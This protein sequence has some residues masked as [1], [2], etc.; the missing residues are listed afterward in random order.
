MNGIVAWFARNAVAANLLM[1]VAFVGGVFG[2]TKMEQEMFPVVNI[3]G[4]SVSVA[5]NGA[6]PQDVE[7]Q[8]VTRIE[9]AVADINGLDRITSIANEGFGVVNIKGRDD[10]DMEEFLDEVKIRVDQINN[11]PQAAFEPQVQRWEQ[12]NWFMGM[13][14][15]GNVDDRTLKRLADQVRDD[16]ANISGGELAVLQGVIDEQVNIEVSEEAL[17]RFGL[18]F[19]DVA[20]AIRRSSLNSSGGRIESST[21]DVSI[22]TRQLADTADQFG[23]IIIRQTTEDGTIRVADI[24]SVDDGFVTDKFSARFNGEP[25]AF[26]MVPSPDTMHIIDYTDAFKDYIERANDPSNGILPEAVKIDILWDDSESFKAR[27][28]L[29]TQSAMMGAVLVMLVLVLFLRPTVAI[30]VT[31]GIMTAFAGGILLLPYF[32]VSWNILSTFAVLLVIGVIV[33]DAIIVGENIHREIESGRREGLDAAIVGTQLVMKPVIFGV[34]TTII[35]FL[36][37]AFIT[38]PT[39]MFTQQI[40]FVVVAALI[41][42]IIECM[43][44]LPSHLAHMKQQKFD[45]PSGRFLKLQR[46]IA[47]SLLWFANNLYKPALELAIR[48]RYA[49]VA[50]FFCLFYLAT[51][52]TGM[53][54]VPFKFMPEIEADLVQVE[55]DMPDGTPYER[56]LQIRDQLQA[57]IE[58]TKQVT[59]AEY[60][61]IEGGLVTD[62]SVVAADGRVQAWI[63]LLAPEDRPQ[64]VRSKEISERMREYVGDI[65][66]A[67]EISFDFTFN[68]E[69][70]G[71]RFAL[72]H[73]DLDRLR[74]AAAEVKAHLATYSNAYDIGDNLSS[75][76]EEIQISLKPG[77]ET[78]GITLADVS[79][80]IRQA[81]FGEEVQRLPRDGEDVRVMVRL[82]E[83]ARRDLD[84]I[85]TLR[86]R[87]PDGREIPIT[88]VADFEFAPGINRI[89]RR[90]RTRSVSVY[91]EV[92]GE[93][94]RGRIMAAMEKD[95]WPDFQRHFPD[96]QRGEAGGFEEEQKFFAEVGRLILIAIG[97]MYILLAVAFRSYAQPI[98]LM[99][100]LP[101]AYC[102]AVFGLWMFNTPM[103]MFSFFGIAAAAG[104]VINDNLVLID[105]VN[106]RRDEGA[107][108]VQA[109]IDGGVSRFRPILLTSVT[110]IVGILPLIAEKSVQAQFLKPMVISL[111]AAVAFALF[112][113]LLF[114]PA[115][116]AVGV[117]I[118]RIFRWTWGGKP[119]RQ[120]G[121]T[122]SGEVTIDEDELIGTSQD[123][124]LGP[125]APAE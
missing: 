78:L 91:A 71:V 109:L 4:A 63:G 84:S 53:G 92:Q 39:R 23:S 118:G 52:I 46:R 98:M 22:T 37:W 49:T 1:I 10:I 64:G 2:Y 29:I 74:A 25:T 87:T 75:A 27:M 41:F 33:D 35:A 119:F 45:G 104:V 13:A 99:M 30:W 42:S 114:V 3:T 112:V 34:L 85:D 43:L 89:I 50:F 113:S 72:N 70:S 48:F 102:G 28:D 121:E 59:D 120:I 47:D 51:N 125:M 17:R 54:I 67:E 94:G 31:V 62:A 82:P 111:G 80:Q 124:G 73:P 57:G 36:P 122:Y 40:T 61:E 66:D 55:I 117:E 38:G 110:T 93:G 77:A 100:A 81:Y 11:L 16:I 65:Q 5:W 19:S 12:R 107:G 108:A 86:V 96:V 101:F 9:E 79:E 26:V 14:V 18:S 15:H 90:N 24:A 115:L 32:G 95:F 83:S 21:G 58:K 103:A 6:S 97:T 69:Q 44:I 88:Q 20:N 76:A 8:I 60:P 68:D 7:E 56:L 106:R 116:Y 123:G 105:Y